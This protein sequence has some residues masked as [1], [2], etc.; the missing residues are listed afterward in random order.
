MD[1]VIRVIAMRHRFMAASRSMLV[2]LTA[3]FRS[4]GDGVFVRH[5][6]N[7]L[8]HVAF[9]RVMQVAVVQIVDVIA[10]TNCNVTTVRPMFVIMA[11]VLGAIAHTRNPF[12]SPSPCRSG[13]LVAGGTT[14]PR[15]TSGRWFSPEFPLSVGLNYT[16]R[17]G[18]RAHYFFFG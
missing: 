18:V 5:F 4:A 7:V 12:T 13:F 9:V 17:E 10:V 15:P 8:V 3:C 1:Q 11:G 14:D 2:T 6:N 16:P